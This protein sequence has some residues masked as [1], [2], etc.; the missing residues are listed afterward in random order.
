MVN[1]ALFSSARGA[2]LPAAKAV[3]W[4]G[5][6]AYEYEPRHKLAQYAVTGCLSN[7][8]YAGA[9]E[10]LDT[11][12]ELIPQVDPSFV[13]KCAV[14]ARQRGMKDVPAL[15]LA[16]LS[17]TS[18]DHLKKVFRRVID[19]GR[20]LRNFVQ[21]LR[22]GTV[23]RK[24]L[25][26]APKGL[27]QRWLNEV[28][29]RK[30]IEASVGSAP[31]LQDIVRMVHP[32]PQD[33]A[34]EAFYGWLLGK[35][36]ATERLPAT[37]QGFLRF[38]SDRSQELPDVPFQMLT[39]LG[40][41][42][43]EWG[44]V[45][46]RGGWQ[47]LR[48][49]LNTFARHGVFEIPGMTG[50]VA[51]KLMNREAIT[52][53][54]VF[55]YQLLAAFQALDSKVPA[56]IRE[57]LQDAMEIAIENIPSLQGSVAVCPD[58]S[59]SMSSPVTGARRGATSVV[60]CIDVAALVTAAVVRK[61]RKAIVLPFEN[62]VREIDLNARD[63][64]MTNAAKLASIGGGGTSCSAP[65]AWLEA[66]SKSPDLVILV[67]DN[68]S[69]EDAR[70]SGPTQMMRTWEMLKGRNR[71]AK[72]V[73]I[74]LQPNGTTQVAERRDILNIGGF[75]DEVFEVVARFARGELDRGHWVERIEA[76][77]L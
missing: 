55:P 77:E 14:Y 20:M 30:L 56:A 63:S 43:Q 76:I 18:T 72:L 22:S 69:W 62:N 58:V 75:S 16:S 65:L 1:K 2:L 9:S 70:K 49:N 35:P 12:M 13:A 38:Q 73:C 66:R 39:A 5:V 21:I 47:M 11:V 27:V 51:E 15:L 44:Q 23:G 34:R 54:R 48:M 24:S 29:E 3:N 19:N 50:R 71:E 33:H 17:V 45:A 67:S 52:Q 6:P 28:S 7:T 59:G 61:N 40:L 36:F 31:C 53:A 8:Y 60:R 26:S 57:A 32:K 37:L 41:S 68:Q 4:H 10:Q 74:D 64:V 46:L 42:R 25:G